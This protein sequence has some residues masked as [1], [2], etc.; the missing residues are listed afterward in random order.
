MVAGR[1]RHAGL[2]TTLIRFERRVPGDDG[3]GNA[4][5]DGWAALFT[6]WA[7]LRPQF[8]REQV[9]AGR[10]ESTMLAVITIDR[11]AAADGLTAA[12]RAVVV[13]GPY[14]GR[15]FNLRSL[16]PTMDNRQ[17]EITAEQGV[18]T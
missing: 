8:G 5:T 9:E 1:A 13:A 12:D 16:A 10:L 6:A 3:H 14:A 18:A 11:H 7:H 15:V 17:I 4:L 2:M